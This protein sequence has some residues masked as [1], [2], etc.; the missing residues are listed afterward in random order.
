MENAPH[1]R[2]NPPRSVGRSVR[3]KAANP[4]IQDFRRCVEATH[5]TWLMDSGMFRREGQSEARI[6]RAEAEV[7]RMGYE[8]HV[9]AATLGPWLANKRL[10]VTVELENRGVAPFYYDWPRSSA[11]WTVPAR[12]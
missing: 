9:R 2:R 6:R 10:P 7:R 3:R 1:R 11:Y 5:A 4:Q 8:F 12:S